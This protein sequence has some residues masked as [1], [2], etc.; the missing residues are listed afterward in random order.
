[1]AK[2]HIKV[3]RYE[4]EWEI[5][6]CF[7][8]TLVFFFILIVIVIENEKRATFWNQTNDLPNST[9]ELLPNELEWNLF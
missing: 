4:I 9:R 2:N 1:M 8:N 3:C 5:I 7:V 6:E